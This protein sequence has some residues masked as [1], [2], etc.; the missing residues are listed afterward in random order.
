MWQREIDHGTNMSSVPRP[1][2][3]LKDGR[4]NLQQSVERG[5]WVCLPYSET[6]TGIHLADGGSL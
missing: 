2:Y 6:W 1:G 5:P 4:V 3:H